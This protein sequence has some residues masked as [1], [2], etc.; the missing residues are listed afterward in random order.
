LD[1]RNLEPYLLAGKDWQVLRQS[2]PDLDEA[3]LGSD[4]D[5]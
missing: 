2:Y 4:V 3:V 5:P 1:L